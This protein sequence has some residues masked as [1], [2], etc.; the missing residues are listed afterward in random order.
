ML[1]WKHELRLF[2]RQRIAIPALLLMLVLSSAS[3]WAGLAEVARQHD[4]IARIQPRQASDEAAVAAW[5]A[6]EGDAGSA[7]YY[8][9][10]ATWDAPSSLA[11]AA[12]GQRDVAPFVLRVRA[13]PIESQINEGENYNAEL[14]L[15]GR[16]DWAFVLTYLSP[17]LLVAL[18]HDLFSGEREAGRAALLDVMARSARML[19][20]RRI[21]LRAGLL[22][23]A[24]VLPFFIGATLSGSSTV[25]AALVAGIAAAYFLFWIALCLVIARMKLG[26]L[27]N[28]ASLAVIWL[29]ITLVLPS[30][31]L[32]AVNRALPVQQGIELT[33][34][35]RE[36]VHAGW[37]KP[38]DATMQEFLRD[39]PELRDKAAF[40]GGFHY[41]W[42]HAFHYLGDRSVAPKVAAYRAGLEARDAWTRKAGL[43]L[44]SVGVQ[45]AI[46]R[47]ARTDLTAQLAYQDRIRAFHDALRRFYY[48]YI[49]NDTPFRMED[50]SKAPR[51]PDQGGGTAQSNLKPAAGTAV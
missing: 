7:A 1:L 27:A 5:V 10:H 31:A 43:V 29:A 17:L 22:L 6:K 21:A 2:L 37:D 18:L 14:A 50:F 45:V 35:Q 9:F 51:W 15:P 30:L 34:A 33:L 36:A 12:L 40:E 13:L 49:F 41:K 28:A 42:Y 38:K 8:T 24:L 46:H 20:F 16:F 44:P 32:L 3:V 26:S 19:W 48:P 25:T 39:F 11:F 4:V 47:L 23:L